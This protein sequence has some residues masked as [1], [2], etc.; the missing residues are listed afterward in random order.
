MKPRSDLSAAV[1]AEA[2]A[3]S[4]VAAVTAVAIVVVAEEVEEEAAAATGVSAGSGFAFGTNTGSLGHEQAP[5]GLPRGAP[6]LAG[7]R[8]SC[9]LDSEMTGAALRKSSRIWRRRALLATPRQRT[10]V[11]GEA[12]EK[13][14]ASSTCG[15]AARASGKGAPLGPRRQS[16]ATGGCRDECVRVAPACVSRYAKVLCAS[17]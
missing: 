10:W 6:W 17:Q 14:S 12:P 9:A 16:C 8:I 11:R 7:R 13:R 3:A 2:V 4:A 15:L 5:P 1:V